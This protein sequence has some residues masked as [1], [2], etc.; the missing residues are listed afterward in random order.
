MLES[1]DLFSSCTLVPFLH[2]YTSGLQRCYKTQ[3]WFHLF[4]F[5]SVYRWLPTADWHLHHATSTHR[6]PTVQNLK[7]WQGL[8]NEC[9]IQSSCYELFLI[10][11]I[12]IRWSCSLLLLYVDTCICEF[13]FFCGAIAILLAYRH[14][15]FYILPDLLE[16]NIRISLVCPSVCPSICLMQF[17]RNSV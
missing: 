8:R 14:T 9:F 2:F 6:S 3:L 11:F 13:L 17:L 16:G 15:H 5:F 10:I 7:W 12:F 4:C 1:R